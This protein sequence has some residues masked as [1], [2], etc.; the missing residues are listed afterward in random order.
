[1]FCNV[2]ASVP[3]KEPSFAGGVS[4]GLA[5]SPVKLHPL[6]CANCWQPSSERP[7][8]RLSVPREIA[9]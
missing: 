5:S 4:T 7:S 3:E 6:S 8:D 9:E 1:M 2:L